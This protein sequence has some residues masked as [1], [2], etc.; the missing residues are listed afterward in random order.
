MVI[1]REEIFGPVL[2]IKRAAS[3]EEGL[4]MINASE[5]GNG[6]AIFTQSGYHAREFSHRVEAGMVGVNVG[7]P[8]PLGFFSFTGWKRSF[9]G[10]LH[11]HG[12]DGV[13]F[14]TEKKSVTYR[15]FSESESRVTKVGTWD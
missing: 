12:K 3:F 7:I 8:V 11:S 14:Y 10:D 15:W 5:F 13:L 1:G 6:A 2:C 4:S 9:F